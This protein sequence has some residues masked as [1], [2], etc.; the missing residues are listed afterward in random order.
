[1]DGSAVEEE[2]SGMVAEEEKAPA[3]SVSADPEATVA[4]NEKRTSLHSC[5]PRHVGFISLAFSL[6]NITLQIF[7]HLS[8]SATFLSSIPYERGAPA[9]I[10]IG[11]G[12]K[13]N[14][15]TAATCADDR[16]GFDEWWNLRGKDEFF[17]YAQ[18]CG[19]SVLIGEDQ[20]F[21]C[22]VDEY[23][24]NSTQ[25][26]LDCFLLP[27]ECVMTSCLG[28]CLAMGVESTGCVDCLIEN[29]CDGPFE[30]CAGVS[31]GLDE[32]EAPVRMLQKTNDEIGS[33][34]TVLYEVYSISF[35]D[36][37]RDAANGGAWWLVIILVCLS[38]IW[39]YLKNVIMMVAWFVPMTTKQRSSLLQWLTRLA[40][41]SLVDVF[42]IVII[43]PGVKIDQTSGG[44]LSICSSW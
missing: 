27:I 35:V 12:A 44:W 39:P 8:T 10:G 4:G 24:F 20:Y 42:V 19:P 26:C 28:T 23:G 3:A 33:S 11:D 14:D 5:F 41:W 29:N 16:D 6:G 1:M 32:W 21:S 40:K 2:E 38:G 17:D 13:E 31:A 37:I 43:C 7:S 15:E 25:A 22:L 9:A 30:A 34:S 18:A 36:S